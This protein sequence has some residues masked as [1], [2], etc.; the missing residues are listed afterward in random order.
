MNP[1]GDFRTFREEF[2]SRYS[3]YGDHDEVSFGI[4]IA[5]YRQTDAREYIINY[6]EDFNRA[7]GRAFDFFI[8][9]YLE[10][11]VADWYH[12]D[13]R[14][15]DRQMIR[16]SRNG[17]SNTNYCF[18]YDLFRQF[19]DELH[20]IFGIQYTFNPMLILMAMEKG[21]IGTARYIV[22]ELD[23]A[24][25]GIRRS[26]QLFNRIFEIARSDN[27]LES[28][29]KKCSLFYIR[30]NII[31]TIAGAIG[32]PWL[33]QIATVGSEIKRYRIVG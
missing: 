29:K 26:G 12:S 11:R 5:D 14:V 19:C 21:Y 7:S 16:V 2:L 8:P 6:L 15:H 33:E 31:N 30:D 17:Y 13:G 18:S 32:V 3:D 24:P 20:S 23:S 25:Y 1:V 22:I 9:G 4:L 10:R 27:S 28:F